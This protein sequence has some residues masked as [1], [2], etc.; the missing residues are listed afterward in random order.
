MAR[1]HIT[2][3]D[4]AVTA[5]DDYLDDVETGAFGIAPSRILRQCDPIAYRVGFHDWADGEGIDPD[6]LTGTLSDHLPS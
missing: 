3:A 2:H 4:E 1:T 5:Y 6:D